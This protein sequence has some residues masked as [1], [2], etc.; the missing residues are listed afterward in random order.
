MNT[1]PKKEDALLRADR[2][3]DQFK[4]AVGGQLD[5]PQG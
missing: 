1:G 5:L 4:N 3:G 2:I